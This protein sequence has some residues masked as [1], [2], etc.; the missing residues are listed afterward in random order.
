VRVD[1]IVGGAVVGVV[2]GVGT[3][4]VISGHRRISAQTSSN[5]KAN[6]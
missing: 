1:V 6:I 3:D 2:V 4:S 5:A